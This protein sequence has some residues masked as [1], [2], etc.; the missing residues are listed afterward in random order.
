MCNENMSLHTVDLS[1]D[2]MRCLV[3]PGV[4]LQ[5]VAVSGGLVLPCQL[6]LCRLALLA[7]CL[8][9]SAWFGLPDKAAPHGS[10][11]SAGPRRSWQRLWP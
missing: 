3:V 6:C 7:P 11:V 1:G 4:V 9:S 5:W 8:Q 10:A 2:D